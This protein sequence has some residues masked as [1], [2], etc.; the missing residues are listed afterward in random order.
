MYFRVSEETCN[1][2]QDVLKQ[3]ENKPQNIR[4]YIAG[5]G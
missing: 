2:I 3:Q 5:M 4:V 1:Q